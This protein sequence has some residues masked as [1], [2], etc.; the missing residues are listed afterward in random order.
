MK[1]T[2]ASLNVTI[3]NLDLIITTCLKKLPQAIMLNTYIQK[4]PSLNLG[5]DTN[6]PEV[7]LTIQINVKIVLL[8]RPQPSA[9]RSFSIPHSL[10][11]LSVDTI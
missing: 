10:I 5:Q 3:R 8:I 6:Y 7:I 11:V 9:S 2:S 1:M 4:V